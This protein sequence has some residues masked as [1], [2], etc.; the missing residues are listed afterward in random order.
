MKV[1]IT[2]LFLGFCLFGLG[3]SNSP[4]TLENSVLIRPKMLSKTT[5]EFTCKNSTQNTQIKCCTLFKQN[6][7]NGLDAK[8][9]WKG[10]E[11]NRC[12]GNAD[13]I[14]ARMVTKMDTTSGAC[15]A[16]LNAEDLSTKNMGMSL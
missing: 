5:Y 2:F 14:Y 15:K 9:S 8:R 3:S 7:G 1:L 6:D 12:G 4:V 16:T 10:K 13:D 11:R